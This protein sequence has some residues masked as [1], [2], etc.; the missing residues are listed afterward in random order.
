MIK[1]SI[2]LAK[3]VI[4]N[5][6]IADPKDPVPSIKPMTVASIA[7]FPLSFLPF[8]KLILYIMNDWILL[9]Q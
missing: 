5:C 4:N 7:V 1:N 3:N 6:Q 8:F 2:P 9:N